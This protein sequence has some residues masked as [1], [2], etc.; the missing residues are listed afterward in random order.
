MPQCKV[1][2]YC[3]R[4]GSIPVL[5]WLDKLHGLD[6]RGYNKC[7]ESINRLAAFGHELRRTRG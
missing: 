2:F 1:I 4:D 3:E 7:V 6:R 5:E